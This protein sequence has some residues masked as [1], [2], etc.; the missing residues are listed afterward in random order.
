MTNG[1]TDFDDAVIACFGEIHSRMA[2]ATRIA[3]AEACALG[4]SVDHDCRDDQ[5]ITQARPPYPS[6]EAKFQTPDQPS[7]I[8]S[9]RG[10]RPL[11]KQTGRRMRIDPDLATDT[12]KRDMLEMYGHPTWQTCASSPD[13]EQDG[14]EIAI[15]ATG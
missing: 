4:G 13:A 14:C 15:Q 12:A 10:K 3:K 6:V 11:A 1:Q 5:G 8:W 7:E 9:G 2:E